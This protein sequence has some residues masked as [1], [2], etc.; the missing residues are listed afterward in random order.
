MAKFVALY[1][2]PQDPAAFDQW[3]FNHHVP[4]V[5]KIPGLKRSEV[6]K[7]TGSPFGESEYYLLAELYF[8]SMDAL[9]AGMSSPEGMATGK[10]AR[11]NAKDILILMF[12]EEEKVTANAGK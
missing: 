5:A 10:D 9:K 4:M 8:D 6:S 7:I 11:A 1:K 3:Y 2:K 12:A